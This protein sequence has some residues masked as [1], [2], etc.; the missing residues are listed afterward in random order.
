MIKSPI[1]KT[2]INPNNLV[3]LYCSSNCLSS[4]AYLNTIGWPAKSI[5]GAI[6]KLQSKYENSKQS[7]TLWLIR[8]IWI[9]ISIIMSSL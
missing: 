3:I 2:N 8:G 7:A 6:K 4:S 5:E 9:V 1:R